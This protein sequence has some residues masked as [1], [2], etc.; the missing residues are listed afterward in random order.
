MNEYFCEVGKKLQEKMPDCGNEFLNYL[1]EQIPETFFLSPVVKEELVS[2]IKKLN[3]RIYCGSDD[4]G[5]KVIQLFPM[6]FV[7][8]SAQIYNHS[9]EICDYPSKL[10]IAKFM[11][12]FQKGKSPIRTITGHKPTIMIQ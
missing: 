11:A 10:K 7:D 4:I 9:I 8:N 12:L 6:I 2:E 3:P 5:A 1:P